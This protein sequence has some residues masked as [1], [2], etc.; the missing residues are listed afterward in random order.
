MPVV[1]VGEILVRPSFKD[2]QREVG[3]EVDGAVEKVGPKAGRT[4]GDRINGAMTK[5]L[6]VG[7]VA[8]GVAAGAALV[9]G[10]KSAVDQQTSKKVLAG[11]YGSVKEAEDMMTSLR[12]VSKK[13][14]IDYSTYLKAAESLAYSGVEGEAATKTLENV[15][16]A[17]TAAGG[18]SEDMDVATDSVMKM[19]NAGKVSLDSLQQLSGSGVPIISGLAEH[20]GVSMEDINKM[21]SKGEIGLEDVTSVMEKGTGK[22]FQTMIKA[23]EEASQSFGNQMKIAKDNVVAALGTSM[24]PLLDR[25]APLVGKVGDAITTAISKIPGLVDKIT[26]FFKMLWDNKEVVGILVSGMLAYLAV[27]K[28][29]A[30]FTAIKTF[31]AGTTL[32]Q[33]GL[34]AAMRANPIGF[35]ITLI[36]LLVGTLVWLYK[37]NE[38]ARRIMDAAWTGIKNAVKFAWENVIK[39][40]FQAISSFVKNVL[41]PIFSWLYQNVIKPVWTAIKTAIVVAIAAVIVVYK[42]IQWFMK[43]VL[44]PAFRWLYNSVIKPVWNAIKSAIK[45]AWDKIIKP[46]FAAIKWFIDNALAPTFRWLYNSVIKPVWDA[47]KS[48]IKWAWER[49]IKP[50]FKAIKWYIDNVLAPVFRWLYKNV[51]KPVWDWIKDKITNTWNNKI[52]PIFQALGNFI[53]DKVAPTF[54]KGVDKIKNIWDSIKSFAKK[55]ISFVID[56]VI[57]KGLIGAF[58]KVAKWVPGVKTLSKVKVPGFDRGGWTGPGRRLQEAGVVHADEFVFQKKSTRKLRKQIGLA[59]LNHMNRYGELPEGYAG[60]GLVRRPVGGRVTSGFGA[61]RGKYPHAGIDFAVPI[62]TAVRAALDGVVR[63]AQW[64]AVNGRSGKGMLLDH[65]GNRSTYY[66]H[67]SSWMAKVGDQVK[68]GQAIARSGNTGRSTGPH[69]HFETWSGKKPLNPARFL[70]GDVLPQGAKGSG[71]GFDPFAALRGIKD[72]ML[73]KLTD[74]FPG[75]A[76]LLDV[77]KGVGGKLLDG[78]PELIRNLSSRAGDWVGDKA[79]QIANG[80]GVAANKVQVR[81]AALPYGWGVGA[82]WKALSQ[83]VNKE[84]SWDTKAANPTTSAR[85]LFQKMTSLHGPVAKTAA[86]QAKWGLNYIQGRYGTPLNAWNHHKKNN[87]YADGGHVTGP[88]TYLH[89]K[90]GVVN[91]GLNSILNASRKPEALLNGKQWDAAFTAIRLASHNQGAGD[92]NFNGPVGAQPKEVVEVI[93]TE[94]RRAQAMA[95]WG[96]NG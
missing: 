44:G 26:P 45:W 41:G 47:I 65:P 71:G 72:K 88:A 75:G 9:G 43:N 12:K 3:A 78:V 80:V 18:S 35:V 62:G 74:K 53:K 1:G 13:S 38:T 84:S 10:F 39:P 64:N 15:G 32:A 7:A 5:A 48:A 6:K 94:K 81:A 8:V 57:N 59:G 29:L 92:I 30:A 20:F 4:L 67:L 19:V 95:G 31:L 25:L 2:F 21:A 22:T 55:P 68:Q 70:G 69:L 61:G 83:L 37:N 86:G 77:V 73:K 46:V 54:K 40:A 90:G 96:A 76:H 16:K 89:D 56:T 33:Q 85:G 36:T 17:I 79:G 23:G 34:N 93:R 52:K 24:L 82:Q 50:A 66:G 14:P 91:P 58:N 28:T 63:K 49:V 87:S 42:S 27:T 11:L 60:G 51:I